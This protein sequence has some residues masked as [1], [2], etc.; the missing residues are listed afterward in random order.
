MLAADTYAWTTPDGRVLAA[1]AAVDD[2][3][4]PVLDSTQ[5]SWVLVSRDGQRSSGLGSDLLGILRHGALPAELL[6]DGMLP[7]RSPTARTG[8]GRPGTCGGRNPISP[9]LWRSGVWR[10]VAG[11]CPAVAWKGGPA[12]WSWVRFPARHRPTVPS[13]RR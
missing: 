3:G 6:L 5:G 2:E 4:R 12:A 13:W 1:P 10:G 11:I 9:T 8:P 7:P